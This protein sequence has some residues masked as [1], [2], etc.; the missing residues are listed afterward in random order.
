MKKKSFV[1]FKI[2]VGEGK[3]EN[4]KV[5]T[6]D[7]R[8]VLNNAKLKKGIQ[9]IELN[10]EYGDKSY[11]VPLKISDV[12][13]I[14][15]QSELALNNFVPKSLSKYLVDYTRQMYLKPKLAIKGRDHE[16]EKAWF[17]LSQPKRNNVF[18]VGEKDVGKTAIASE[19]V[20]QISTAE[21]PKEF[22]D[23]HV[24]VLKVEMLLKI[25]NEKVFEH[26]IKKIINFL[27]KNK[28]KVIL[29]VDKALYM[30]A[31]SLLITLLYACIKKY[32]IPIVTTSSVENFNE[33]F[34]NDP[35]ISKYVNYI[36]VEEPEIEEIKPMIMNHIR[37]LKKQY[38]IDISDEMINF[39]VFTSRLSD[40]V[41][42]NPGNVI[43]IFEMAFLEAKRKDKEAVDKKSILNCYRTRL[44]EYEKTPIEEKTA[45]AYHETGHY[46][47][48]VKSE[49]F[50]DIKISCVSNLPM[51]YWA[52]VT[53]PYHD[54]EKYTVHSKDYF[55]DEIAFLLGGGI[56]EKK[57]TSLNSVGAS[58]DLE[59][60][61]YLAREMVMSWG[62]SEDS[63]N[64]NRQ[65]D[66]EYYYLIPES[67]KELIDKE[68]KEIIETATA[69]AEKVIEENEGLLKFIAQKLLEEEVLS[70]EQLK[71]ICDEYEAKK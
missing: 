3:Y 8:T 70:G 53:M 7:L 67:K 65:Y 24:L 63:S 57:F 58:N 29:F 19:I 42:A 47:L 16:I 32:Y 12:R 2:P 14:I 48:A 1:E 61:N 17:Y 44:K 51:N 68:I 30:K 56:A 38:K 49:H 25:K 34:I 43:S 64:L 5:Y 6:E 69:R 31:D 52:G 46:I 15:K 9:D 71:S 13:K 18:L 66:P 20:R 10:I 45:T 11:S 4:A 50:K 35:S 21:C 54:I 40:S 37:R 39:G 59:S 23:T 22:Y 55:I 62:F 33:Y 28:G 36:Y 27:V 26:V 41:S 60:A